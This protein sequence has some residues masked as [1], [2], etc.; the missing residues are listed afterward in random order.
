MWC[1]KIVFGL[2][3]L[4]FDEFFLSGTL[5]RGH[6]VISS[7]FINEIARIGPTV[8][9]SERVINVLNQLPDSTDFSSLSLFMRNT[10]G[11]DLS[12]YLLL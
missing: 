9:F 6:A 2:T 5:P 12:R 10:H 7:N 1:Y 11:M 3:V 8:F 4:K